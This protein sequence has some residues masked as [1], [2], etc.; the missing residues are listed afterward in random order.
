[1]TQPVI[2]YVCLRVRPPD[3]SDNLILRCD[4]SPD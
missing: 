1:V 4:Q 2:F 3:F